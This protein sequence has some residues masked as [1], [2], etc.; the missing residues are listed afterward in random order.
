MLG[1]YGAIAI[2]APRSSPDLSQVIEL[3]K[4]LSR[5]AAIPVG[6]VLSCLQTVWKEVSG[7]PYHQ[8]WNFNC[9]QTDKS[10]LV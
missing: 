6:I 7:Q 10:L 1:Y 2:P 9:G 4:D 8:Q 5:Q 3:T